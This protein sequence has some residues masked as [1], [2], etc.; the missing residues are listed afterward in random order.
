MWSRFFEALAERFPAENDFS[1][2]T[3]CL[4]KASP[5]F[6]AAFMRFFGFDFN[7]AVPYEITRELPGEGARPDFTVEQ[8][9]RCFIIENKIND[10]NYHF[11]EYEAAYPN[12]FRGF[13]ANYS[14]KP[15]AGFVARTWHDFR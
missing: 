11:A 15:Q 3:Y 2:V 14:I 12:A 7:P 9:E 5:E 6:M 4:C 13:I 1:D 8:G 10:R